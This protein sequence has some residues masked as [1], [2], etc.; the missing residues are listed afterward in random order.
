MKC[1][2]QRPAA[3]FHLQQLSVNLSVPKA[4]CASLAQDLSGDPGVHCGESQCLLSR[5]A[6]FPLLCKRMIIT[7]VSP[8]HLCAKGQY[9]AFPKGRIGR[10]WPLH[11][12]VPKFSPGQA[13]A[14]YSLFKHL[15]AQSVHLIKPGISIPPVGSATVHLSQRRYRDRFGRCCLIL[16][17]P[18]SLHLPGMESSRVAMA[19]ASAGRGNAKSHHAAARMFQ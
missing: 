1:F 19:M 18:A 9:S 13:A 17:P 14:L 11:A 3:A 5:G 4:C 7:D 2:V 8:S 6:W 12:P 15:V 16:F 10:K